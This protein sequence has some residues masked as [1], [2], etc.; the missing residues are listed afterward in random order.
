MLLS[1]HGI[2]IPGMQAYMVLGVQ[3]EV[4]EESSRI[5]RASDLLLLQFCS[6]GESCGVLDVAE[7][8]LGQEPAV[9]ERT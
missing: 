9:Y 4:L 3:V 7:C 8:H 1:A 5:C 2:D 6:S